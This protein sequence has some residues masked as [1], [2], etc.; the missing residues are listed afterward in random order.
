MK[1]NSYILKRFLLLIYLFSWIPGLLLAQALD[2]DFI[3]SLEGEPTVFATAMQ[4]DGKILVGG[5]FTMVNGVPAGGIARLNPGGSLDA[6]FSAGTGVNG[7]VYAITLV[8]TGEILIGGAFTE[9][10][11]VS[12]IGIAKLNADGSVSA[13]FDSGQGCKVCNN[14]GTVH[15]IKLRNAESEIVIGGYFDNYNGAPRNSIASIGQDGTIG[16][17][18]YGSGVMLGPNTGVIYDMAIAFDTSI[19][20]GGIFDDYDGT[21]Q[22]SITRIK[23]NGVWDAAL[24]LGGD[25]GYGRVFALEFVPDAMA[26]PGTGQLYIGGQLIQE[27]VTN[28]T[29]LH[30]GVPPEFTGITS[31]ISGIVGGTDGPI[32]DLAFLGTDPTADS[33]VIAGQFS[34]LAFQGEA[35]SVGGG[36]GKVGPF[37][38]DVS[39]IFNPGTGVSQGI[40]TTLS[41]DAGGLLIIGGNFS[42]FN[43]NA[44]ISL[45]RVLSDGSFDNVFQPTIDNSGSIRALSILDDDQMVVGGN[46][47]NINGGDAHYLARLTRTGELDTAFNTKVGANNSITALGVQG[48]GKVV[49]GGQFT[50]YDSIPANYL[51][52]VNSDGSID[53]SFNTAM[54]ADNSVNAIAVQTRDSIFIGGSF[55]TYDGIFMPYL[56]KVLGDGSID[57]SF[58]TG[59]GPSAPVKAIALNENGKVFIG[60]DFVAYNDVT[61]NFFAG[62]NQDGSLDAGFNTGGVGPDGPVEAIALQTDGKILLGG[63]FN[64]YNGAAAAKIIR[65]ESDGT[66]DASFN[67]GLGAD[68]VI[69]SIAV[70]K[71]GNILVGGFF[72]EYNGTDANYVAV[73]N[74]DGSLISGFDMSEGPNDGVLAV[75]SNSQNNAFI[76]G[77]FTEVN[78]EP[79][80]GIAKLF[81]T[82]DSTA[83]VALY[84]ATNGDNWKD[85]TGWLQDKVR[86]WVGITRKD[87]VVTRIDLPDNN[88]VG[89]IPGEILTIPSL[90]KLIVNDNEITDLPDLTVLAGINEVAAEN[91]R[92]KFEDIEPNIGIKTFTYEP[93]DSISFDTEVKVPLGEDVILEAVSSSPNNKYQW[94]KN[95]VDMSGEKSFTLERN[96]VNFNKMAIYT[97]E[98]TNTVVTDLTLTTGPIRL[99]ATAK[100]SGNVLDPDQQ[101]V[102]KANV[103]I[104]RIRTDGAYDTLLFEVNSVTR[105]FIKVKNGKYKVEDVPLGNFVLLAEKTGA[106]SADFFTTYF[107]SDVFWDEADTLEFRDETKSIDIILQQV[108]GPTTGPGIVLGTLE[109]EFDDEGSR[110]QRRRRV[111][112][113]KVR[114]RRARVSGRTLQDDFVIVA[115]TS[116]NDDGEFEFTDLPV[117]KYNIKI[118]IPG[119]P[120]DEESDL[121]IFVGENIPVELEAVITE[122]GKITVTNI[123]EE[124]G[125]T[126]II[127]ND[128]KTLVIYPNPTA[129]RLNIM[130]DDLDMGAYRL[131]ITNLTGKVIA[132]KEFDK[133]P[134][135]QS[136]ITIDVS[137]LYNG[138]YILNLYDVTNLKAAVRSARLLV[139]R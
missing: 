139:N 131:S 58:V 80:N 107:E 102:N 29:K 2:Q 24:F 46:F 98:I 27:T 64:N 6:S 125:I 108:P 30:I 105:P 133:I 69:K 28:F 111:R 35:D 3:A 93:Q 119:V 65:L 78:G 113:G 85:N 129:D 115:Q 43:G 92:L 15:S 55:L 17:T 79:R 49:I 14:P 39:P 37:L 81:V 48:N 5:S 127:S 89:P 82:E 101:P 59:K 130:L 83:L 72:N 112:R 4:A 44:V 26:T 34:K 62:L 123:T 32:L 134:A 71:N 106:D 33:L 22:N 8:S 74:P 38:S 10:D 23:S 12:L 16:A 31:G 56:A 99:L 68:L 94:K 104:F 122:D 7:I 50:L 9:V 51:A 36:I 40:I 86:S 110:L 97:C 88:L 11:G 137:N 87:G 120:M 138:I 116:T 21:A 70:Q 73:L 100:L 132:S 18:T 19:Y 61:V 63:K 128:P 53:G 95:G 41:V 77:G 91:N 76:A 45:A 136:Q 124:A 52:R 96:N 118:D 54:G 20:L 117:G 135:F 103:T 67:P 47:K 1:P 84:E 60:G 57:P 90:K 13:T 126:G 114:L 66:P 42:S 25:Q 75:G 109:E 121:D